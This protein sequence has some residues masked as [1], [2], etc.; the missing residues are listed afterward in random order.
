[1]K[2]YYRPTEVAKFLGKHT[3]TIKRWI[4]KGK[5]KCEKTKGGH[6]RIPLAEL[7]RVMAEKGLKNRAVIFYAFPRYDYKYN[8][9]DIENKF[10]ALQRH[11]AENRFRVV[12]NICVAYRYHDYPSLQP[13][14][15][16]LLSRVAAHDVDIVVAPSWDAILPHCFDEM[17]WLTEKTFKQN[18]EDVV[19]QLFLKFLESH[20]VKLQLLG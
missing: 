1:M 18:Y 20:S 13:S 12:D 4:R 6:Y 16:K 14:I 11:C 10:K 7:D 8:C 9:G 3:C 15:D 5:I 2:A 19:K 17:R